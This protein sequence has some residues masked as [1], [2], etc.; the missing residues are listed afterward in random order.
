MTECSSA[1]HD[2]GIDDVRRPPDAAQL[3]RGPRPL[4]VERN[5]FDVVRPQQAREPDLPAAIPPHLTDDSSWDRERQTVL[6]SPYEQRDQTPIVA[7]ERDQG[8]RV[9]REPGH[10]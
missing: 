1:E 7:L 5:D 8:A 9:Q 2:G 3:A 10:R 4:V 6:A